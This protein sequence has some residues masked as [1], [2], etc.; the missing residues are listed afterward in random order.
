MSTTGR[1]IPDSVPVLLLA[2]AWSP[3]SPQSVGPA[4][5][6]QYTKRM[7]TPVP[8]M[9]ASGTGYDPQWSNDTGYYHQ[10]QDGSS[11]RQQIPPGPGPNTAP[12]R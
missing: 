6:Q 11:H 7:A 3:R 5:F 4:R 2:L 9:D 12:S 8:S 1:S 10:G